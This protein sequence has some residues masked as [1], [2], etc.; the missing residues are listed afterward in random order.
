[1]APRRKVKK[2][3]LRAPHITCWRARA[4][5]RSFHLRLSMPRAYGAAMSTPDDADTESL[6]PTP[7]VRFNGGV[8]IDGLARATLGAAFEELEEHRRATDLVYN[9]LTDRTGVVRGQLLAGFRDYFYD[10]WAPELNDPHDREFRRLADTAFGCIERRDIISNAQQIF[11]FFLALRM[12]GAF[13]AYLC[14]PVGPARVHRPAFVRFERILKRLTDDLDD[15]GRVGA[16]MTF[17]K[18]VEELTA[19][20]ILLLPGNPE[21]IDTISGSAF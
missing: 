10:A 16:R 21:E 15:G 18:Y 12:E 3:Q 5:E 6:G 20:Y 14:P 17:I 8:F 1:M 9:V 2:R 4:R 11:L 19:R 7:V 13:K